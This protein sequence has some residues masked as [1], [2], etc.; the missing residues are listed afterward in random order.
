MMPLSFSSFGLPIIVYDLPDPVCPYAK[1]HTLYLNSRIMGGG[2][3]KEV[4][5][6]GVLEHL[7]SQILVDLLLCGKVRVIL[8]T[9]PVRV[10]EA[11]VVELVR[12]VPLDHWNWLLI[13]FS[14]GSGSILMSFRGK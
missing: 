11:E 2:Q 12:R 10:V 13:V 7:H 5:L 6:E 3:E 9:G 14:L 1:I 8:A 4:P